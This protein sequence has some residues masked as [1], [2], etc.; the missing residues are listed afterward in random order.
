MKRVVLLL[1]LTGWLVP[2]ASAQDHFQV[3]AYGDYFR[4]TQ[5]AI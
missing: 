2:L 3:G 4:I 1:F 5:T